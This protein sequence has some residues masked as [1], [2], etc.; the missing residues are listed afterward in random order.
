MGRSWIGC[1]EQGN[2]KSGMVWGGVKLQ[3]K[4]SELLNKSWAVTG[5]A[6]GQDL[7]VASLAYDSRQVRPGGLFVAV[8]GFRQDGRKFIPDALA[9]GA[10]AVVVDDPG[11][12]LPPGI[13]RVLV[14]DSRSALP[15]LAA[16]FFD[17]PSR[18]LQLVGITGTNGK[19]TT[20]FMSE[21]IFRNAGYTTGLI[22]TVENH[23][24]SEVL[25][26]ERTTPESVDVEEL[27]YRMHQAQ[28]AYAVMEVSS[29]ALELG[30]VKNLEFDVA[31]FTN[32]TQDHLDF[33]ETFDNYRTAKAKLFRQLSA[34]GV[35]GGERTAIINAD[36]PSG[37]TMRQATRAQVLTYGIKKPADIVAEDIDI[38]AKAATFTVR[39]AQGSERIRLRLTGLFS[40]YNAL[41]ACGVGLALGVDLSCVKA[42]LENLPGVSGRFEQVYAGQDFAVIVDY[43]HTPDGLENI[44]RTA[45]EFARGRILLVFGCGGDRD[46]TKRPIMGCLAA[47]YAD[48]V[49]ITS[50]NPRSEEPLAIIKEIEAGARQD[51]GARAVLEIIPDRRAAIGAAIKAA[52]PEDVVLIAGKGHETYQII[53]D[54]VLPF[55]DRA[56]ALE[57]LKEMNFHAAGDGR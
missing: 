21:A 23:V 2:N 45:K 55:D 48:L 47:E 8:R 33:H 56:V 12:T 15:D 50:D 20:A 29:H 3:R 4:L 5:L 11:V 39:C 17:Y 49:F 52:R 31:V 24:G 46:R 25:P 13:V 57:F 1:Q 41:A 34:S 51:P 32:L 43:A 14:P 9:R 38:G 22:G 40:V 35:R 30:R 44:L 36:D 42:A 26:V 16:A 37:E 54:R 18:K 27:L 7:E 28:V 6:P 53:G 19:T 10:K